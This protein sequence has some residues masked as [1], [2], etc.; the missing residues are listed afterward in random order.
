MIRRTSTGTSHVTDIFK[1]DSENSCKLVTGFSEKLVRLETKP[2]LVSPATLP[3]QPRGS[4]QHW[5]HG[6]VLQGREHVEEVLLGQVWVQ[7][8]L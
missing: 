8:E 2:S 3:L 7:V 5:I 6:R 1:G 4:Q